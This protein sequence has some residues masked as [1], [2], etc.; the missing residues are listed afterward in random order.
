MTATPAS[1][2]AASIPITHAIPWSEL[3]VSATHPELPVHFDRR[4]A[5]LWPLI[6]RWVNLNSFTANHAGCQR[7][8]DE[9]WAGFSLPGLR[10]ERLS[11]RGAAD[12]LRFSTEAW[13]HRPG[14]LLV[15]HHD[16]VFPPHTFEGFSADAE[17]IYGPGVLDMKGGLAIIRCALAVLAD[18]GVL[19]GM[20]LAFVT[21]S[22]EETG[23]IDGR[24]VLSEMA[25]HAALG[26]IF[27]AGRVNDAIVVERKGTGKLIVKVQGRAAHAGNDLAA[28]INAIWALA[29]FV[30]GAQR[31]SRADGSFTLNVGLMS[32]GTS[33]NT[34]PA[35][36]RCEIDLRA[37]S[38]SDAETALVELRGLAETL[39][40]ETGTLFTVEGG[41][42]R[43]PLERTAATERLAAHY[44]GFA[45]AFGLSDQ[46][47]PRVGG[48]SDANTLG[49]AGVPS[50][51]G[52]GPRGRGFHT[53]QEQAEI[54]TF[55]P[56]LA[57]LIAFLLT[58]EQAGLATR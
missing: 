10:G 19:A 54:A 52:L 44:G 57:S 41:M 50:I 30:D 8:A 25:P 31:Q 9:L 20:P 47:S 39:A 56:R 36:A 53:P 5:E 48:G 17:K 3:P 24:R 15:G 22:D 55:A 11:G 38:R 40:A 45:R 18:L 12:H 27:E 33:A 51:D 32:G 23:S 42:R 4:F 7:V 21:V 14:V 16:T 34:V 49:E 29:R 26:L 46:L 35:E 28:G 43:M 1:S 2:I 37:T 6:E 13:G 58:W